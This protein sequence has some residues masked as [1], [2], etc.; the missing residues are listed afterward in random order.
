M[1]KRITSLVLV[2]VL[3]VS[4]LATAVPALAAQPKEI[5]FT[6]DKTK[7]SPGETV[8]YTVTIGA[9]EHFQSMNFH[10]VVPDELGYVS[11]K[12]VD[13]LKELLGAD[14]A[15][16]TDSTRIMIISGGGDYTS[17]EDTEIM[18]FT[19][20]IPAT[21]APGDYRI[22]LYGDEVVGNIDWEEIDVTWNLEA[23]KITVTAAPKPATDINLNKDELTLTA[24]ATETLEA[25]VTPSDTTDTVAWSSNKPE[26]ATVDPTTGEVTAVAPGEAI[27]TAKA[28]SVSATCTVKVSCAHSLT[29]VA[30]KA[31]NCTEKG[32]DEYQKCTLCGALF[33]M[34]G[35]SIAEIPYRPLNNDHDFN[36]GEWGYQGDDGHA[37]VCT[38][39]PAHKDGVVAHTSSGPATEDTAE[40]CT[41]CGYEIAPATGHVCANHLTK[42]DRVEPD[43]T[44][45]GN[46]EHYKCSGDTG[47][48]KLYEDADALVPTTAEEVKLDALG[49][50]WKEATCTDPKTCERCGEIEGAALGHN[51]ATAWS[52]DADNHWHACTR[53]GDKTDIDTHT[54][55]RTEATETDPIKCTVCDYVITPATGHVCANHLTKV[56]RVEPDCTTAGNIEHYK[57][58]GDTGCGKLYEDADALVPTTA[59]EV[60]LD[61]LGHDWKA[62]TCTDPKTCD[63]CHTTEGEALG[64]D[65]KDATCTDP[66]TCNRCHTTDGDALGHDWADTWSKDEH[67][68]WHA[69]TRCDAK[70]GEG[71]HNPG[72][73]ATETTPQ[74]CTDCG[75]VLAPATGHLC[76]SHLEEVD[77]VD[78]TCTETGKK[79]HYKCSCGKL[80]W[81][82]DAYDPIE[83]PNEL[84]IDVLEHD[85]ADEWKSDEHNHWH[86]CKDCDAK[87]DEA[88]HSPDHPDGATFEYPV[89]CV[90]CGY[91]MEAQLEEGTI[92]VE[93]PF[94]LTVEKTG[95][96]DPG[97]EIFKFMAEEFGAPV[98]YELITSTLETNGAKTYDGVFIFTIMEGDADNLSEGFIFRQVKGD[99]EGW[100]YDET[101]FYAV[102]IYNENG[103]GVEFWNIY[104]L[105]EEGMP[106]ED[107]R[108]NGVSF[109]NSYNAK[110]PVEPSEPSE[111][112]TPDDSNTPQ[113]GDNGNLALWIV[114]LIASGSAT[115]I[116]L[117][118]KK[119]KMNAK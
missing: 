105:D 118:S 52:S 42:V 72:A 41:V 46:I 106:D 83:D 109:T 31:S 78:P 26:V 12:E 49:H 92:R 99:A 11:G 73:P 56:D 1:N 80:Y 30:E 61:A 62:A 86:A 113:T 17:T 71:A 9:I 93:L 84:V 23:S 57:C 34:S 104:Y 32:W 5:T 97:K 94:K 98:E 59:E 21:T 8:T 7:V 117:F 95:E 110:K 15:E 115:G 91:E 63:R 6:P 18:K 36:M 96:L 28:G 77:K 102:P 116:T 16:Y 70:D 65:W 44:T 89:L 60:K 29:T 75:Y 4:L 39:N 88:A 50:D 3:V 24:G 64:H 10:L 108:P 68:H 14:K 76:V 87:T 119:R 48:G 100:T 114:L 37:H 55:D 74:T 2:F 81:D 58:S 38:R 40:T 20:K 103:D 90:E 112:S 51:W 53:C 43:C 27:I 33:D 107:N 45:A 19:C 69:C 101:K 85:W 25:T 22:S 111:P 67:N 13:G 66:K 54:P 35:S 82:D 79:A 47:C